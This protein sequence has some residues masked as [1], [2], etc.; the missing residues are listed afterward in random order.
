VVNSFLNEKIGFLQMS[1][2]IEKVISK[3]SF[4]SKPSI[5]DYTL[6]DEETRVLTKN[7][8]KEYQS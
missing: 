3:S 6:T 8:I 4:I 5:E 7:V 2:I 1:E